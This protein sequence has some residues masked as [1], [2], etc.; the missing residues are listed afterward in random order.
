M[1]KAHSSK[2]KRKVPSESNPIVDLFNALLKDK[3][4]EGIDIFLCSNGIPLHVTW[5]PYYKE[6]MQLVA[7]GGGPSFVPPGE[8]KLHTTILDKEY[9]KIA[10]EKENLRPF[11]RSMVTTSSWM[12]G[13]TLGIVHSSISP[14]H[15]QRGPFFSGLLIVQ[16]IER[17]LIFSFIYF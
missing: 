4:G 6:M 12:G 17:M 14:V 9:T 1:P 7:R 8:H 5:S 2:G 13:Q 11:G 10:L 3:I 15:A 16:G